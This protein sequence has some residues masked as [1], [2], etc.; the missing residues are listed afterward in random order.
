M[1][2]VV[3]WP[4]FG[5]GRNQVELP[6]FT[7]FMLALKDAEFRRIAFV[8]GGVDGQQWRDDPVEP[9]RRVE[10]PR[11]RPLVQQVV[12]IARVLRRQALVD[13]FV[14][15]LAG[16]RERLQAWLPPEV[17]VAK[18]KLMIRTLGGCSL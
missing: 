14:P 5:A 13:I 15:R 11:G 17:A 6:F 1:L 10:V 7:R 9:R 12:G 18:K 8:V 4:R 16:R 3:P 2:P